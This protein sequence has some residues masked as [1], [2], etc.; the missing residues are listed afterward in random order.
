MPL[1]PIIPRRPSPRLDEI[2][3]TDLMTANPVSV[4]HAIPVRE[5]AAVLAD[6]DISA[7][8]VVNDAGRAV[9]V[10]SRSD[11]LLAV[12]A[13][14]ETAPVREVMTPSVIAVAP[15]ASARDIS[16]AMAQHMVRRVFVTDRE[17]VPVGVV[18]TT[19]LFRGLISLWGEGPMP[20]LAS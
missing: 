3:A 11:I 19:D 20:V 4:R 16:E 1:T 8:P 10:L 17:G 13:G 12:S 7:A 18:S 6:R 5:A 9:G 2:R 15:Q 14:V